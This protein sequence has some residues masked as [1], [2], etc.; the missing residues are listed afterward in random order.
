MR[1]FLKARLFDMM[2]GDWDR[3][4]R[5]WRW[6][7]FERRAGWQPIPEDRDTAFSRYEGVILG[8]RGGA[9]LVSRTTTTRIPG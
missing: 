4:R 8:R 1:A 2:I 3:H 7:K 9:Y 6:A 5:Q